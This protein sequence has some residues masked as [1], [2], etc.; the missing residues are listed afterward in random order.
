LVRVSV[1][2]EVTAELPVVDLEAA[3]TVAYINSVGS[4]RKLAS[5]RGFHSGI[6][7]GLILSDDRVWTQSL[8]IHA[9]GLTDP[10]ERPIA[11]LCHTSK[12]GYHLEHDARCYTLYNDR[13]S[14]EE[15]T[16][17]TIDKHLT[18]FAEAVAILNLA[19]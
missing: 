3:A 1:G 13:V 19:V 5:E 11:G 4:L 16:L 2:E 14:F 18:P 8:S 7:R 9:H 15:G 12:W 10:S 17:F 6:H